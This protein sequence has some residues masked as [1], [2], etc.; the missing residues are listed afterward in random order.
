MRSLLYWLRIELYGGT[1]RL[2]A[3]LVVFLSLD[4]SHSGAIFAP[5]RC[6]WVSEMVSINISRQILR[7][8]GGFKCSGDLQTLYKEPPFPALSKAVNG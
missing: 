3:R 5:L 4:C 8:L 1:G 2:M 6:E 7:T